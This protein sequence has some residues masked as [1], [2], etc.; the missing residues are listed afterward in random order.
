MLG[1]D[2]LAAKR[3]ANRRDSS[4]EEKAR[5]QGAPTHRW[6]GG[7]VL[8]AL[9][10][11]RS[12]RRGVSASGHTPFMGAVVMGGR[13]NCGPSSHRCITADSSGE[14]GEG[15]GEQVCPQRLGKV[16]RA[17]RGL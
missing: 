8:G 3:R 17:E 1:E 2:A 10:G 16:P 15:P 11:W 6:R 12:L 13:G 14:V 7:A 5:K 4:K 9:G